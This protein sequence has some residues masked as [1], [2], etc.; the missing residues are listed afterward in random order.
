MSQMGWWIFPTEWENIKF[1][2]QTTNQINM[3]YLLRCRPIYVYIIIWYYMYI[4]V[5]IV[6][7]RS[8][9]KSLEP[10][11]GIVIGGTLCCMN[12]PD[13]GKSMT[14]LQDSN[15]VQWM[16][17]VWIWLWISNDI[18]PNLGVMLYPSMRIHCMYEQPQS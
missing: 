14:V 8:G 12:Q 1:M 10:V 11:T 5:Y 15:T 18:H 3:F 17:C 6:L 13:F 2:F 9:K 16:V 4:V 7:F